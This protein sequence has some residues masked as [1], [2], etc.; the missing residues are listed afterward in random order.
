MQRRGVAHIARERVGQNSSA[1]PF[2]FGGDLRVVCAARPLGGGTLG[3]V[4][5]G[6]PCFTHASNDELREAFEPDR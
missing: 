1:P 5:A 3:P 4:A 2:W 6:R